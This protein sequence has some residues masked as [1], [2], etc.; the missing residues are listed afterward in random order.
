MPDSPERGTRE[1]ARRRAVDV[2][3]IAEAVAGYA[4]KSVG[5]GLEPEA[6]RLA[7]IDAAA[8]LELAASRLRRLARPD[9]S[10]P[11]RAEALELA[12]DGLSR[13]QIAERLGVSGETAR[14]YLRVS[15]GR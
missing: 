4:A 10:A 6:A 7:V 8:E 11:R 3:R 2:L 15:S 5:N 12:A 14:R 9:D 1:A 13:R